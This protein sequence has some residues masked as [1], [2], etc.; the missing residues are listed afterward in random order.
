MFALYGA[1]GFW[2]IVYALRLL[3]GNAEPLPLQ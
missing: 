1:G 2:L 3:S